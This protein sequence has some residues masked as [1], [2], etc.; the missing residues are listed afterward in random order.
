MNT[1]ALIIE[2]VLTYLP[3]KLQQKLSSIEYSGKATLS[4]VEVK[5][6]FNDSLMPLVKARVVTDN[7]TV[8]VKQLPYP[9]TEVNLMA[10]WTWTS[11]PMPTA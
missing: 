11:T 5:G 6:T 4:E 10:I 7:V 2:D 9:F 1:S 8:N 3:E